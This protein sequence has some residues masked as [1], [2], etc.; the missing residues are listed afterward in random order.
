MVEIIR[1]GGSKICRGTLFGGEN[2]GGSIQAGK[3]R[4]EIRP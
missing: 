4:Q 1:Q 2:R 3:D